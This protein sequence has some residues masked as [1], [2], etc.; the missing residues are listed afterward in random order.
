M[1]RA[2][3]V[4]LAA[5]FGAVAMPALAAEAGGYKAPYNSIGQPDLNGTWTNASITPVVRNPL[6]GTRGI[7][8][9]AEVKAFESGVANKNANGNAKT[10]FN[11]KDTG[12]IGTYNRGWIDGGSLV[13]RVHGEPRTSVLTTP[14]GQPP[15]AKGEPARALPAG[16][17][18]A[19][20]GMHAVKQFLDYDQ[21][22]GEG[23]EGGPVRRGAQQYDNPED[24]PVGDRCLVGFGRNGGPPMF[25]N[26]WYNNNYQFVQSRDAVAIDIEMVHDTRVIRLNAK[27]RT[28][29]VRPWFGDS[30]GHFEGATLVVETTNIPESEEYN[31]SWKNLKVTEKFTRVAKDRLLYQYTIE[32]PTMWDKPWGGEYEFMP[33]N[34]RIQ[35]YACHEGNYA[36]EGVLAGARE[37]EREAAEQTKKPVA[38]N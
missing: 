28:D 16:A 19:E 25:A 36:L 34:G 12:S 1:Q 14:D 23:A 33:T 20:A 7:A 6:F 15:V 13:M 9:P 5:L 8:S 26:G 32:D 35:E 38:S 2:F 24:R 10:D 29:G 31:G 18:S 11:A 17:G 3:G 30:I 4:T 37:K 22:T 27:H 21:L